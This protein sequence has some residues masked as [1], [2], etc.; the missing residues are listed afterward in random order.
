MN[1]RQEKLEKLTQ[2]FVELLRR[3]NICLEDLSGN[4]DLL[5]TH[6]DFDKAIDLLSAMD[7]L[8]EK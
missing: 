8:L 2:E 7:E 4:S 5:L 3:G 6:P 1:D